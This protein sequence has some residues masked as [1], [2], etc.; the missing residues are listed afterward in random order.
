MLQHQDDIILPNVK[1][2][3]ASKKSVSKVKHKNDGK[4]SL[5]SLGDVSNELPQFLRDPV[6]SYVIRRKSAD[7]ICEVTGADKAYFLRN[8]E[9][10]GGGSNAQSKQSS[11][12][13]QHR[14]EDKVV[15]ADEMDMT[16]RMITVKTLSLEVTGD[17]IEE[18]FGIFTC[19][20]DA[21]NRKGRSSSKNAT[22]EISCKCIYYY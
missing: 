21:W 13:G 18:Y 12:R 3:S 1:E 10:M 9:A 6:D 19:R 7:L 11:I 8:G 15:L 5:R 4:N 2:S 17:Q 22:V 14:E 20:C 16:G